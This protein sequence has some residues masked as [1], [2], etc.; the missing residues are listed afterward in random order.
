M[1][2][3]KEKLIHFILFLL[4]IFFL[5]GIFNLPVMDRD[6]ARFAT[7]SKTMM[8][9]KDFIDIKMQDEPRY[10]KP[11]GIYWFQSISNLAFG[12]E[13]YDSIWVYRLP[14]LCGIIFSL[15]LI[16]NFVRKI[17]GVKVSYLS[18][19]FLILS[20]LTISELHQA[21]TD[22][23]L[24]FTITLCNLI[25]LK[26]LNE[27]FVSKINKV[28]FWCSM[29]LG[30]LIKGPIIF[31]FTILPLLILSL[32]KQKNFF[33][34]VWSLSGLIIF[35]LISIPWFVAISIISNGLFWHESVIND[36]FNKVKSGQESHGFPP[37][38]YSLLLII[39][40]WPGVIFIPNLLKKLYE[41]W[42]KDFF[43]KNE[44][45]FLCLWFFIPFITYEIIP[46]KLP[47]Y[48]F[49]S[50][51]ALSILIS[52]EVCNKNFGDF[53]TTTSFIL[54]CLYP[55]IL[56]VAKIFVVIEYSSIDF[57]LWIVVLTLLVLIL[58]AIKTFFNKSFIG[59][60]SATI[61]FQSVVYLSAVY[62]L[63]PKLELIW[64][65]EKINS[66]IDEKID[67]VDTVV[68]SGFNEPSLTFLTS[69]KAKKGNIN[70]YFKSINSEKILYIV[71]NPEEGLINEQNFSKVELINEFNGFN[72]SQGKNI[73]I[74][75]YLIQ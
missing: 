43:E 69:H 53:V 27:G 3:L 10:K 32:I 17:Y 44:L 34:L 63:V 37:G 4:F 22:A 2:F 62:Y 51:A 6:E 5:Q 52:R 7:A 60:V 61:F 24:F 25:L 68:H 56:I 59:F 29:G 70:D 38:Y 42:K 73:L 65:S 9:N 18:L 72:Y 58:S 49:P 46:T 47:H 23:T 64:V 21:K 19:F 75:V 11:I 26:G 20:L 28:V 39:M 41:N 50:Y 13:P 55:L 16:F 15:F 54:L 8:E 14:S 31:I 33:N 30:V 12:D 40:F 36:L 1:N 66:I 67:T 57:K 35:S 45:V 48:I 71:T 74:K